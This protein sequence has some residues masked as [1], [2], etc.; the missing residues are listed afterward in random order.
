MTE[1][2]IRKKAKEEIIKNKGIPWF[3]SKVKWKAESDIFGVWDGLI[4]YPPV[5]MIPIQLTT[6]GNIRA[7]EKKIKKFLKDR[8]VE[9]FS[10][11]W[12]YDKKQKK[13]RVFNVYR[14]GLA[15]EN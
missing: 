1:S 8:G 13:F 12:A 15:K 9:I 14:Q 4:I 3:T 7:R 11:I 2:E 10:Q 6:I 5:I